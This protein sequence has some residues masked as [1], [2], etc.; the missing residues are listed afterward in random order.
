[1]SATLCFLL[2]FTIGALATLLYIKHQQLTDLKSTAIIYGYAHLN[3]IDYANDRTIWLWNLPPSS[4]PPSS[5]PNPKPKP[6]PY[7]G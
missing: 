1:M 4:I 6:E 5:T 3:Q 2:V 7:S